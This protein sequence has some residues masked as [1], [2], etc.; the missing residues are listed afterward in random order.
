ML[1]DSHGWGQGSP[2]YDVIFPAYSTHM[3]VPYSKGFFAGLREHII[4]KYDFYPAAILPGRGN[5]AGNRNPVSGIYKEIEVDVVAPVSAA[6]YYAPR[7][8][9]RQAAANLG[10]LA[11]NNKFSEKLLILAP[12]TSGSAMFQVDMLTHASKVYIGVLTGRSG[13]KLE[14]YFEQKGIDGGFVHDQGTVR[15]GNTGGFLYPQADG[16]PIITTIENGEHRVPIRNEV[17][18]TES[19]VVIDTF[20]PDGNEEVVYC[21]D[22][23]Q[24]QLGNLCF[25]Y[26]GANADAVAFEHPEC[27]CEAPD[28]RLRGIIFD[29]NNVRNF[30]MGGH[31]VGQWLGDGT[32]SFNDPP[33]PHVDELL[34]YVPFTPQ[35]TIIQAPI[36]NEYL[37]QTPIA[38]FTANLASLLDKLN[39]HYNHEGLK[40][41]DVLLFTTPGDK[42]ITYEGGASAPIGYGEYYGAVKAFAI[43]YG[44]GFVDFEQYFRDCVTAGLLDYEFLFDDNIHPG[45]YVNEF[46]REMLSDIID[47]MM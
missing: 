25:T 7:H 3:S 33:Y 14:V 20:N 2:G 15:R 42:V 6:G 34:R 18:V 27:P 43:K 24:K 36:V 44:Y 26:A 32:P 45:P 40:G 29:G 8:D 23:G 17:T 46:I 47:L 9:E 11:F 35:L 41:M 12:D 5:Q 28:L 37:R 39:H 13:A 22:Y 10:Y 38:T 1:G 21:I 30:S 19:S 16:Y 31:T 4:R